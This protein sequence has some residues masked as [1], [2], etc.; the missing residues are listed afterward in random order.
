MLVRRAGGAAAATARPAELW[1]VC[2]LCVGKGGADAAALQVAALSAGGLSLRCWRAEPATR[3]DVCAAGARGARAG[4]LGEA[5]ARTAWASRCG[6]AAACAHL[7]AGA[8]AG[9]WWSALACQHAK[10]HAVGC[11]GRSGAC[12]AQ[13]C[14]CLWVLLLRASCISQSVNDHQRSV[15][16]SS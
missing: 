11:G 10:R 3:S 8:A 12:K 2:R 14:R 5:Y 4:A 16:I 15:S 13:P 7:R 1:A 9:A 6:T